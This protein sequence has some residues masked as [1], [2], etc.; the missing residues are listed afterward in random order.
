MNGQARDTDSYGQASTRRREV[1]RLVLRAAVVLVVL[2][3]IVTGWFGWSWWRAAGDESLELAHTR[4]EVL[5][6]AQQGITNFTSLDHRKIDEG[7]DRLQQSATGPLLAEVVRGREDN[8]KRIRDAKVVSEARVLEAAV[9]ELDRR[10]G[11]A[12][13]I[14][15]VEVEVIRPDQPEP[16]R[17]QRLRVELSRTES[18]WKLSRIGEVPLGP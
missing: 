2:A 16:P 9:V 5:R 14:A 18:G 15:A 6:V 4:D 1:P 17:R 12:R 7:F 11:K 13:V 3:T 10:A 8:A